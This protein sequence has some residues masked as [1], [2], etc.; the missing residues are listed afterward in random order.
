MQ[1]PGLSLQ[2]WETKQWNTNVIQ[3]WNGHEPSPM[4]WH[5]G[6]I[7]HVTQL[8]EASV[9]SLHHVTSTTWHS[10]SRRAVDLMQGLEASRGGSDWRR[11]ACSL[12][13]RKSS[14]GDHNGG[15]MSLC[16]CENPRCL[17]PRARA[18]VLKVVTMYHCTLHCNKPA[19]VWETDVQ[20]GVWEN[21]L[22][23]LVNFSVSLGWL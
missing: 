23:F 11:G 17:N 19:P 15:S 2:Y 10:G 7:L 12:G 8:K 20:R 4:K 1:G 6:N 9:A 5:G 16:I 21:S 14:F 13:L 3:C 18:H 22:C